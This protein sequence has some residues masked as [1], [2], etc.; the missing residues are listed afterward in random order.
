MSKVNVGIY[1]F[2]ESFVPVIRYNTNTFYTHLLK[3]LQH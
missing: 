3:F 2:D 1:P